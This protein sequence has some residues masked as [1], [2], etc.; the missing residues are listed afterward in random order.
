MP[1]EPTAREVVTP[2]EAVT[3][4]EVL[5]LKPSATNPTSAPMQL[6]EID[7]LVAAITRQANARWRIILVSA[8]T[9]A[10]VGG[11]VATAITT[12][13]LRPDLVPSGALLATTQPAPRNSD[14]EISRPADAHGEG[15]A[16][17]RAAA[18]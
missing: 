8:T 16:S 10:L 3:A 18:P 17:A 12:V 2:P 11:A 7:Q 6:G 1:Q 9:A 5:T 14:A 15:K 4:P 13:V